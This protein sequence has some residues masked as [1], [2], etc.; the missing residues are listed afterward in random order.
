MANKFYST[1]VVTP[2]H[3]A[4]FVNL[5]KPEE[6]TSDDGTKREEYNVLM[7]VPKTD[8]ALTTSFVAAYNEV[9]TQMYGTDTTRWPNFR[10]NPFRDGDADPTYGNREK[11]GT[12]FSGM[13]VIKAT[14]NKQPGLLDERK[15][16]VISNDVLYDGMWGYAQVVASNYEAKGNVGIK[17]YINNYM[18]F[19]DDERLGGGGMSAAQAFAGIPA[20]AG[21]PAGMPG[22]PAAAPAGV[23]GS[24]AAPAAAVPGMPQAGY[25]QPGVPA[26]AAPGMPVQTAPAAAPAFPGFQQPAGPLG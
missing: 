25:A 19:K 22:V 8:P 2:L 13:W 20:A 15:Q 14:S 10:N 24:P 16:P 5:F 23:P 1:P 11:Y 21:A 17:F 9:M 12:E 7:L 4:R 6:V 18:K 3:R 26:A